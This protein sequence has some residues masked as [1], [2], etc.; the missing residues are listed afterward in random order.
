MITLMVRRLDSDNYNEFS[1]YKPAIEF[2]VL[3]SLR[4]SVSVFGV[5]LNTEKYPG[6]LV[7]QGKPYFRDL[8]EK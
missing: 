8:D 7:Y 5:Y 4:D 1:G 2:A 3:E 6:C